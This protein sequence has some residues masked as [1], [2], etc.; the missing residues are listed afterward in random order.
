MKMLSSN[1]PFTYVA[2]ISYRRDKDC[3]EQRMAKT[4][5]RAKRNKMQ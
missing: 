4:S 3:L 1:L 5:F 2:Q